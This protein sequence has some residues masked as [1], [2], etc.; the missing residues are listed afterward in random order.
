VAGSPRGIGINDAWW[1][2]CGASMS[3]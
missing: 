3:Y 1:Q 2:W